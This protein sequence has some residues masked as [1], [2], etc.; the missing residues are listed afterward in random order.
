M[1]EEQAVTQEQDVAELQ[2]ADDDVSG[3]GSSVVTAKDLP[4]KPGRM[5]ES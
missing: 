3:N 4:T 5:A 2:E 1:P